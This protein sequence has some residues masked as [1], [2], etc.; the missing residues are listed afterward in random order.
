MR[1]PQ[2]QH[3]LEIVRLVREEF[4]NVTIF[5]RARNRRHA[6]ELHKLG[7]AYFKRETFDSSLTLAQEAMVFLGK[8]E[9]DMQYKA[10]QF[11]RHDEATLHKS[12]EFFDNEP[13]LVSFG[14][15]RRQELEQILQGDASEKQAV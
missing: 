2:T 3:C 6:Y 7:V 12:F 14:R 13:E 11:L 8:K 9:S 15:V 4:P 1:E 5:A 10:A